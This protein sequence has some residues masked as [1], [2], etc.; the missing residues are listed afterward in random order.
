MSYFG[1]LL[2]ISKLRY[3]STSLSLETIISLSSEDVNSTLPLPNAG[4]RA[5]GRKPTVLETSLFAGVVLPVPGNISQM[6]S[7]EWV[8]SF[9]AAPC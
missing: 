8:D 1:L 5:Q 4:W 7:M 9:Q 6:L 2:V 3:I